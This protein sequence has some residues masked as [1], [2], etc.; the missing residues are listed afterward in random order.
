[1]KLYSL[2]TLS[3]LGASS[4][5]FAAD[6]VKLLQGFSI[7]GGTH[8]GVMQDVGGVI[9]TKTL[10]NGQVSVHAKQGDGT[11]AD[12][13]ATKV[14]GAGAGYEAWSFDKQICNAIGC[15][16]FDQEWAI[17][18][19]V[20]G[21]EFWDS[22]NS[23]N[24]K[25]GSSQGWLLTS[26]KI[27]LAR[28]AWINSSD[29]KLYGAIAVKDPTFGK[30]VKVRY[31]TDN[32]TW[33]DVDA[34][35]APSYSVYGGYGTVMSPNALGTEMWEFNVPLNGATSVKYAVYMIVNGQQTWDNNFGK[36][37]EISTTAYPS[38]SVRG[39]TQNIWM[40]V[41]MSVS[42]VGAW[43]AEVTFTAASN[44]RF[45]FDVSGDW[46]TNFGD[47]APVDG[48]AE[49]NGSDIALPAAGTYLILFNDKT[50][51]YSFTCQ[52]GA[53]KDGGGGEDWKRTVIFIQ[54]QTVVG[55]DLFIR[56]GI[57]HVYA[58]SKGI[59]CNA[60]NKA[61]AIPIKHKWR[62]DGTNG[63]AIDP[64]FVNDTYLDWYGIEPGQ[65]NNVMGS[66]L[67]WT[68]NVWPAEWGAKKTLPANGYGEYALNT[69]GQ[70]YWL[71]EVD[72]D[73]AKTQN[74]WFELK[75]FLTNYSVNGGWEGDIN[76]PGRPYATSNHFGQCGKLNKFVW[77]SHNAEITT[78]P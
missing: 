65:A 45:K 30:A 73:C 37:Y 59:V 67:A 11:W 39:T 33:K 7:R 23:Q 28:P 43:Q 50:K 10:G 31:T 57:D 32:T 9:L 42:S 34:T 52:S 15:L 69:W 44:N 24:Y 63:G 51:V 21:Q 62:V 6:E 56:G 64:N 1:M 8:G 2:L 76:Q 17:K 55:Q 19:S 4:A 41:T 26:S 74:G 18:Y 16:A 70:H 27:M 72:M 60:A 20:N 5:V 36:N 25:I 46:A 12:W 77:G 22:N 66:P 29:G 47:N 48:K 35:F 13:P 78:L 49:Q 53:C 71:L 40:P 3:I 68:T 14:G 61:C 58:A 38:M 75:G 54:K